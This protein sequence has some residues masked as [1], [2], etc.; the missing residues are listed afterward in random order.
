MHWLVASLIAPLIWSFINHV[1]K[2][3]LSRYF[4]GG[5]SGALM[6]FVGVVAIPA[7]LVMMIYQPHVLSI[8]VRDAIILVGSGLLYNIAIYLYLVTLEKHDAS[9]VVPFWQ[10]TPVC[11]YVFGVFLLGEYL[12]TEKL[13][14]AA[15]VMVG[16]LLLSMRFGRRSVTLDLRSI[17]LMTLS[18]ATIALGYVFFK[19]VDQ[20]VSFLSGMFWNQIGMALFGAGFFLVPSFRSD[21]YLV[22]RENSAK[23]VGLNIVEQIFEVLGV[24]AANFAVLLAPAALVILVEYSAQPVFVFAIGIVLSILFPRYVKEDLR[25]ITL[26]QRACSILIMMTGL[27]FV[28]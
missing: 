5:G 2:L 14:G 21:F 24:A 20:S 15:L 11:A 26:V 28:V 4:H 10:L 3:L 19:D 6:I 9:Y 25:A 27:A 22:L 18:S 16:A 23:V 13:A 12:A 1:D 8:D 17:I 7:A